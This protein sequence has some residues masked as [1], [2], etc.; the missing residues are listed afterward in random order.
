MVSGDA[1]LGPDSR[2]GVSVSSS[3]TE[4]IGGASPKFAAASA[5]ALPPPER[6]PTRR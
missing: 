2:S 1:N 6:Y 4:R 5:G 3:E